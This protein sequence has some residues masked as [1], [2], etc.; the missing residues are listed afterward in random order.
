MRL[1]ALAL[2]SVAVVGC[3][4][5]PLDD[6]SSGA[7]MSAA[8]NAQSGGSTSPPSKS[9]AAAHPGGKNTAPLWL[10]V[11]FVEGTE[12]APVAYPPLDHPVMHALICDDEGDAITFEVSAASVPDGSARVFK[13]TIDFSVTPPVPYELP[14]ICGEFRVPLEGLPSGRYDVRIHAVDALGLG[15]RYGWIPASS[16]FEIP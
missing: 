12:T 6:G 4:G 7:S 15:D 5:Q 13:Q 10:P 2:L 9:T 8:S 3:G 16:G 11:P 14:K 1:I